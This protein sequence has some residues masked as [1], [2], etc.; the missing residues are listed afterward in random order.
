MGVMKEIA[1]ELEGLKEYFPFTHKIKN[2]E[3]A[4]CPKCD[5][6]FMVIESRYGVDKDALDG[7]RYD[8]F[9]YKCPHCDYKISY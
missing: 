4:K 6:V 3:F 1:I 8:D 9:Y 5:G 2:T 7:G